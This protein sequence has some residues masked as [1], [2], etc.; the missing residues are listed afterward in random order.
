MLPAS[1][2]LGK[3]LIWVLQYVLLFNT[4]HVLP[5]AQRPLQAVWRQTQMAL[6]FTMCGTQVVLEQAY[7][8]ITL[9]ICGL[10]AKPEVF[11]PTMDVTRIEV[12][13][14]PRMVQL[15]ISLF[16]LP[17]HSSRSSGEAHARKHRLR[18][19]RR[20]LAPRPR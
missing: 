14:P 3:L 18:A 15:K 4:S 17:S 16:V 20:V 9:A 19:H 7:K 2:G 12:P 13:A 6:C 10:R 11:V 1:L 5:W 8:A